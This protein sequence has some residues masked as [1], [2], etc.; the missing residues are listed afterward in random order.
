M[1]GGTCTPGPMHAGPG[2][3]DSRAYPRNLPSDELICL[4]FLDT[5]ITRDQEIALQELRA[6]GYSDR[7]IELLRLLARPGLW[8]QVVAWEWA[9]LGL[10]DVLFG[11]A[12][13]LLPVALAIALTGLF[14]VA[15]IVAV[16]AVLLLAGSY[17]G[18]SYRRRL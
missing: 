9:S 8:Y 16:L 15:G 18:F 4:P 1:A 10:F 5:D 11:Y 12:L 14:K 17:A 7:T 3:T 2:V 6:R 13:I